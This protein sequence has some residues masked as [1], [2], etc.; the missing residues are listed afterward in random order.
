MPSLGFS[1]PPFKTSES[2]SIADIGCQAYFAY[3]SLEFFLKQA[4]QSQHLQAKAGVEDK[5]SPKCNNN[6]L[7][8]NWTV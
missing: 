8:Q 7:T 5:L 3:F 2:H 1:F 6:F 4:V